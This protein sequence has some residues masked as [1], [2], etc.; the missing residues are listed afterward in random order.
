MPNT[1]EYVTILVSTPQRTVLPAQQIVSQI[2]ASEHIQ[3]NAS[4][5]DSRND[6]VIHPSD[7]RHGSTAGSSGENPDFEACKQSI[8]NSIAINGIVKDAPSC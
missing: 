3:A 8:S 2:Q 7:A 6:V 4:E 5:T 1:I